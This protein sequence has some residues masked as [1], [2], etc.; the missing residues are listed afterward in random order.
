MN[1][2]TAKRPRAVVM[3]I[4]LIMATVLVMSGCS[5]SSQPQP[6]QMVFCGNP[7][8]TSQIESYGNSLSA[9][10]PELTIEGQAPVFTSILA[11]DGASKDDT[12]TGVAGQ[13]K[14]T[15]MIAG[16]EIDVAIC[17]L[18]AAEVQARNES[19]MPL[20]EIFT[21]QELEQLGDRQVSYE[22]TEVKDGEE[23]PTGE[24]TPA[25]GVTLT[26]DSSLAAIFGDQ[27]VAVFVA[28]NSPNAD[29]AK[30][31]MRHLVGMP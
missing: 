23:V 31:V 9:S 7:M 14:F 24:R 11:G 10:M 18:D 22:L 30:K 4:A 15:A 3:T 20:E 1:A 5:S 13:T 12:L 17:T 6:F 19:F 25:C 29:L 16:K 28:D 21:A 26:S 27:P 8:D 2:H